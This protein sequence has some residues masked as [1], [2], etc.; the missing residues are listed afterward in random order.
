MTEA[1]VDTPKS[2]LLD[3]PKDGANPD[4]PVIV[5]VARKYG[6]SPVKQLRESFGLRVGRSQLSPKEYYAL[7]LYDPEIS[8]DHKREFIG[9]AANKKFNKT[10]TPPILAPTQSF[11]GNKL[12]YT[13][14]LDRLGVETSETQAVVS[15]FRD[16]GDTRMLRNSE[17]IAAFL[18]Q[19]AQFPI[20]GKPLQGSQSTGT[21]RL[22]RIEGDD[23]VLSNGQTRTVA[24]FAKEVFERYPSGYL[25][26]T[27]LNSHPDMAA[28]SGDTLGSVRVVTANDGNGPKPVYSLWKLSAPRAMSD[29]FWQ[30]GSILALLDLENG[31][32][33]TLR[34]GSGLDVEELTHHPVTNAQI[35]GMHVPLWPDIL[36]LAVKA[37][38]VLPE[39]GVC[40]F[41]IAVTADG[42]KILECNNGPGHGLYQQAAARDVSNAEFNPMLDSAIAI[43]KKRLARCKSTKKN[44]KG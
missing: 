36:D 26:Q 35:V 41:D 16:A 15:S 38:A 3:G 18:T 23:L 21:V 13:M 19:D 25:F 11:V 14:L 42:P 9:V 29:N 37:H 2:T 8:A 31:A 1:T 33:K 4:A 12:L 27:A 30:D 28:I 34:R 40:G 6:V 22:E 24:D 10:L 5:Q 39:F 20:F 7:G 43:Q 32:V 17:S 44:V